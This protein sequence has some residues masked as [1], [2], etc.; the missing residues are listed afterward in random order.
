MI[1]GNKHKKAWE[2]NKENIMFITRC[3]VISGL[4][5]SVKKIKQDLHLNDDVLISY[6][7]TKKSLESMVFQYL[8]NLLHQENID[9]KKLNQVDLRA[10]GF[11]LVEDMF[12]KGG[13]DQVRFIQ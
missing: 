11:A 9:V 5:D 10:N 7:V 8:G 2:Q 6:P 3:L 12:E 4:A 1:F 13:I